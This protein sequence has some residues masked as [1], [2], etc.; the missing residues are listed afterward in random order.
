MRIKQNNSYTVLAPIRYSVNVC[1]INHIIVISICTRT[2][3]CRSSVLPITAILNLPLTGC[4][5]L[6]KLMDLSEVQISFPEKWK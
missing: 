5:A 2:P 4:V 3:G 1:V 6:D